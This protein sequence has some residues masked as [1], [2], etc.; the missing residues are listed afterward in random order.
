MSIFFHLGIGIKDN[1]NNNQTTNLDITAQYDLCIPSDL[2]DFEDNQGST[3]TV[4][5]IE[6]NIGK[7]LFSVFLE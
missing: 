6:N 4:K 3:E 7:L 1:N 5:S 2:S